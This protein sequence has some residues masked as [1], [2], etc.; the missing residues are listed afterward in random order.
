MEN[1]DVNVGA[2]R[3]NMVSAALSDHTVVLLLSW[4]GMIVHTAQACP[5][6]PPPSILSG[7][8][9]CLLTSTDSKHPGWKETMSGNVSRMRKRHNGTNYGLNHQNQMRQ[10]QDQIHYSAVPSPA[11]QLDLYRTK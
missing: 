5:L 9:G 8:P 7:C 10:P 2:L 1:M 3:V 6:P 11:N 4:D